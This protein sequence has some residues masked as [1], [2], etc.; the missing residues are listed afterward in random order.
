MEALGAHQ[1]CHRA[2][3]RRDILPLGRASL[4]ADIEWSAEWACKAD[5][6]GF[7]DQKTKTG[8]ESSKKRTDS[9]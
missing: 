2:K 7:E 8:L 3:P 6:N 1:R 4:T 9:G 5:N